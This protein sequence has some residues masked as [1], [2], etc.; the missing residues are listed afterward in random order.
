MDEFL[1][2]LLERE[3]EF[4]L[5]GMD[6]MF[7]EELTKGLVEELHQKKEVVSENEGLLPTDFLPLDVHRVGDYFYSPSQKKLYSVWAEKFTVRVVREWK[8]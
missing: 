1:K 3:R 4:F 8:P 7:I 6:E 5:L 2:E